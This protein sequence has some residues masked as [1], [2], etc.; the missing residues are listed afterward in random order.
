MATTY[1]G[2]YESTRR[3]CLDATWVADTAAAYQL[4][5]N[6]RDSQNRLIDD[7]RQASGFKIA[8]CIPPG[9]RIHGIGERIYANGSVASAGEVQG[10]LTLEMSDRP[11]HQLATAVMSILLQ[12]VVGYDVTIF[13]AKDDL[14]TAERMASTG[15]GLCTP[16]HLDVE[17]W[18]MGKLT[19]HMKYSGL[20]RARSIGYTG[21]AGI[22]TLHSNI[23]TA[24][25]GNQTPF[26]RSYSADFWREYVLSDDLVKFY[27]IQKTLNLTRIARPEVCPDGILGCKNGC[28]KNDACTTAEANGRTCVVVAMMNPFYN[29]GFMESMISN[30]RIPAYFCYSTYSSVNQYVLDTM[31]AN[32]TVLFYHFEPD[33]FQ[34]DYKG[35]LNRIAFPTTDPEVVWAATNVY[36]ELG[37]GK[38]TSNPVQV[39]FPEASLMMYLSDFLATDEPLLYSFITNFQITASR[40]ANL[41]HNY[42]AYKKDTSVADPVFAAACNWI[43]KTSKVWKAWI[44]HLPLCTLVDHM[45]YSIAGCDD[46]MRTLSFTWITPDP[47]NASLPYQC[48]GGLYRLP[49][50]IPTSKSCDWIN[51]NYETWQTWLTT[52]P[53]CDATH[54]NYTIGP[55]DSDANRA[56]TFYWLLPR[57]GMNGSIE[58]TGGLSLPHDTS[59]LCDYLPTSSPAYHSIMTLSC[60]ILAFFAFCFAIVVTF[61]ERPI[62]KRAQWPLLLFIIVGGMVMCIDIILASGEPTDW[63]CASQPVFDSLAFSMV[64]VAITVKSLRVYLLFNNKSLKKVTVTLWQMLKLYFVVVGI[65]VGI[66][67][68]GL[69]VDFPNPSIVVTASTAFEGSVDRI[70]CRSSSIIFSSISVF[71]KCIILCTGLYLAI[72]IRHADSDFQETMWIV[73]SL[74]VLVIGGIIMV[75]VVFLIE[76][77]P[78]MSF[79]IRSSTLLIGTLLVVC[80]MLGPKLYRL[81]RM[82]K[83]SKGAAYRVTNTAPGTTAATG[84]HNNQQ[85]SVNSATGG[86]HDRH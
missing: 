2:P 1:P 9:Q 64:F 5:P 32:G 25:A 21:I 13:D 7:K 71:W 35:L 86:H 84:K 3:K 14:N 77:A 68:V 52:L 83:Q 58:C 85:S 75:P 66:V 16:T 28:G 47:D 42:S 82:A 43:R 53:K 24:L 8:S 40:M 60:I 19:T 67:L 11:S 59:V 46:T 56:V 4:D 33:A 6:A 51:N 54:Y 29:I 27:S 17:V 63:L 18:T 45:Y 30:N 72:K 57:P 37:Y 81:T 12:E 65:D 20:V 69:V 23:V 48:D 36:G 73:A 76:M 49:D 62:I 80:F 10:T 15:L 38:A 41:L 79:T 26:T 78:P 74:A 70:K 55:C 31:K 22:Y 61:R 44:P 39:D 50:P 34:E